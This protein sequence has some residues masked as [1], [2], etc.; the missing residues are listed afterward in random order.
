MDTLLL[1]C[2]LAKFRER[3]LCMAVNGDRGA[4]TPLPSVRVTA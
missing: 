4:G 3:A 1:A 2:D